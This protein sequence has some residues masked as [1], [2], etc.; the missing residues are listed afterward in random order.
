VFSNGGDGEAMENTDPN[1][2]KSSS[3]SAPG[4]GPADGAIA[5]GDALDAPLKAAQ[6]E[7]KRAR[8]EQL[9]LLAEVDNQRKRMARDVDAARRNGAERVVATLL[10]VIDSLERGLAEGAADPARL[11]A[12]LEL[13]LRLLGKALQDQGL[14]AVDPVGAPFDPEAH[15]AMS[16]VEAGP[17]EPGTVA[18]VLQK[19]Y[20]LNERLLRP[21]LVAVAQEP[22]APED[23]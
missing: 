19:G 8:D 21:A 23:G 12:G 10:P 22:S 17:H 18:S 2:S 13:T 20:R 6:D 14:A 16:V 5:C 7:L 3:E 1:R 4:A 9:R 15:Q 11:R